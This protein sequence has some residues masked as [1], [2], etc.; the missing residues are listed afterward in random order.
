MHDLDHPLWNLIKELEKGNAPE[1]NSI[2][3]A[4]SIDMLNV[5]FSSCQC[6]F[7]TYSG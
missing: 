5:L 3:M 2:L 1:Y 6:G 4:L 7:S